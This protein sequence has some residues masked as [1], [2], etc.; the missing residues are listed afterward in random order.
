[1]SLVEPAQEDTVDPEPATPEPINILAVLSETGRGKLLREAVD[2]PDLL[3]W[4]QAQELHALL[5]EFNG[6]FSVEE[7]ERGR[8]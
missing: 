5:E 6:A 3:D 1:M 8:D 2:K 7:S 4:E